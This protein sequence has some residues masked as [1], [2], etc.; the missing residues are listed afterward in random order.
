MPFIIVFQIEEANSP[1]AKRQQG[2]KNIS[3]LSFQLIKSFHY[4]RQ[5]ARS[6]PSIPPRSYKGSRDSSTSPFHSHNISKH[7]TIPNFGQSTTS[8]PS[9]TAC[10]ESSTP[11]PKISYCTLSASMPYLFFR[12]CNPA[13][14]RMSRIETF[15]TKTTTRTSTI[16]IMF[17]PNS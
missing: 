14:E 8:C 3:I 9:V 17:P 1:S 7:H 11:N 16:M 13:N 4:S 6:D 2:G 12:A 5:Q 15:K 10:L